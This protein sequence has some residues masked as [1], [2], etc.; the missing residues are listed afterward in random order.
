MLLVVSLT[1]CVETFVL[2]ARQ[3][4]TDLLQ[5]IVLMHQRSRAAHVNFAV[6]WNASTDLLRKALQNQLSH[7]AVAHLDFGI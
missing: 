3:A 2:L 6:G 4:L 7:V 5:R 1:C